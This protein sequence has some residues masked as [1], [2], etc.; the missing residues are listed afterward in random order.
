MIEWR[1][2]P[3]EFGTGV[4]TKTDPKAVSMG[5]FLRL[6][7]GVFTAPGRVSKR[8]GY[9]ALGTAIA[10]VGSLSAPKM[11]H[12][13]QNELIAADQD[14]LLSYSSN[15]DAWTSKGRYTSVELAR[16]LISEDIGASGVSS[17]AILG[18]YALYGW[19]DT[20]AGIVYGS[21]VDLTTG[22]ILTRG[23]LFSN[24][25]F[26][27]MD[28]RC[29]LLGGTTLAIVY[30]KG[31]G[32][33]A[34][35]TVS[36]PGGGVATFSGETVITTNSTGLFD[37]VPTATGGAFIYSQS[38][39]PG[40][41]VATLSTALAVS[42]V[43]IAATAPFNVA[44]STTSNGNIWAYWDETTNNGSG[45]LTALSIYYAVFTSTLVP[46]LA[47]TL[48][49]ATASP[50][51]VSNMMAKADSATQET[52]YYGLFV[53]NNN[54]TNHESEFSNFITITSAGV[55]GSATLFANGVIPYSHPF[56][57]GSKIY[58]VF[59]YRASDI[60]VTINGTLGPP[61]QPTLF[62]VEL[63]NG[64]SPP[65]LAPPYVVARFA[66]GVASSYNGLKVTGLFTQNVA[67][68]SATKFYFTC[69]V[70]VQEFSSPS[71]FIGGLL[72]SYS[73]S[74]DFDSANANIAKTSS[75]IAVLNGAVM[76]MYDGAACVEV[77][78]HTFP[79]IINL[80]EHNAG[81]N[82][83]NGTY[84]YI[85]IFTWLDAQGNLHQSAPS[86]SKAITT[87]SGGS[88]QSITVTVTTNFLSRKSNAW[89]ALYRTQTTG[90]LYYLVTDPV[91]VKSANANQGAFVT[92]L[93]TLSDT[94]IVSR[95]QPYTYPASP[96]L[97][98]STPAPSMI[99]VAHNNRLWFVDS[100]NPNTI[101]YT[102][103][104]QNQVGISPSA[105]LTEQ[106]DAKFGN[107]TGLAEMD[108]KLVI[109]KQAGF[110][111]QAGDGADDTGNGSSL[112]FPQAIP[113]DVGI[114]VLKSIITQPNGVMFKSQNGIYILT[115]SLQVIYIGA[116]VE[117]YN[118]QTITSA[119]L[120][121]GKSQIRFLC[122]SGLTLVYDYIY[123]QWATFSNHTGTSSTFLG[124]VYYYAT[125]AGLVFKESTTSFLDNATAYQL[126]AQSAW[127]AT[128][129]IQGFQRVR[130]LIVLGDYTNGNSAS[131]TLSIQA[132]YDFSSTFQ[133]SIAYT[134]G[135]A[136]SAAVFQ[137]RERLAQQKCD[138]VSFLIQ[139]T[140]S[141][142]S[143]EYVDLTNISFEVGIK[144]GVNKLGGLQSVG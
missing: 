24:G 49:V 116:D 40:V 37:I 92:F 4:D 36:F 69:G 99:M 13:Y 140:T 56:T 125:S 67:A 102:K 66:A 22:D 5:K 39:T 93:D 142:Q 59:F 15:Q 127:I 47:K 135:L 88:S 14:L 10:N 64:Q 137:Y 94:S 144:R 54:G 57:V 55:V 132:A 121:P 76:Q 26:T 109:G 95:N 19:L 29:V 62:I 115:R 143:A 46:V 84:N 20:T 73:Y 42:A 107:I 43:S 111:L 2:V 70:E 126:L 68:F 53:P 91:F 50:Y 77:G 9:T 17:V 32:E 63:T 82:I 130:R 138:S 133:S 52:L 44:I 136:L 97:E 103:S 80:N 79:E 105:F 141:G 27:L 89:V 33:F 25:S 81:G 118:S 6:E 120:V 65:T 134:F 28:V 11:V 104:A 3:V 58:A 122:S 8:N 41:T 38:T 98:N 35:R 71:N 34:A 51:Y 110:F 96:V 21:V 119:S 113:S 100:E 16:S 124:S 1:V 128:A 129:S 72:G 30:Q 23:L 117:Q 87:S 114:T 75:D 48:I 101:W 31:S 78:F 18:N 45:N 60:V 108:E 12:G 85:A 90:S 123:N 112:S 139:E 83:S 74:F 106:I 86:L 131:H 7:N 61:V